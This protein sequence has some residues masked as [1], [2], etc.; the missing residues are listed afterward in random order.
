MR[1]VSTT[2]NREAE[3]AANMQ[4]GAFRQRP[5]DDATDVVGLE[6]RTVKAL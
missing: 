1:F 5:I 2:Q 4:N 3:S 6:N